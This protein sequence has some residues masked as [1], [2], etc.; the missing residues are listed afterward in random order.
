[1]VQ[2]Y[3]VTPGYFDAMRQPVI[4]GRAFTQADREGAERSVIVDQAFADRFWPGERAL[5]KRVKAGTPGSDEPWL[6]VVGIVADTE[7]EGDL[8]ESWY[9]PHAQNGAAPSAR[10]AHVMLRT[11]SGD[12]ADLAPQV[13]AIVAEL[14]A[15]LP[16]YEVR[17]MASLV[18]ES[19]AQDRLGAL[20]TALFAVAGLL[21]SAMGLYGVLSF[22][23]NED[24]REI[25][26]RLAL[27]GSRA[28]VLAM[29]LLR[30][31]HLVAG[32][33]M[34]GAAASFVMSRLFAALLEEARFDPVIV[35]IACVALLVTGVLAALI[36]ARRAM[37]LNPIEA[38]RAD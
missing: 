17:T 18:Q 14:D 11:T 27:G 13:R 26:V 38:L 28:H 9:L 35:G 34:A 2:H 37:T 33:L 1:V 6:T 10:D 4:R 22:A 23:V 30:A 16:L 3:I 7:H 21:L 24:R 25:G 12:V 31:A 8:T 19:L 20:V 15:S 29:V 5:G 36:P 32:G